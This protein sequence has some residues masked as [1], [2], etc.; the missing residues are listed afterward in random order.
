MIWA[1]VTCAG[2]SRQVPTTVL[3]VKVIFQESIPHLQKNKSKFPP[4]TAPPELQEEN[5]QDKCLY[6]VQ[7]LE[8]R[9]RVRVSQ[10]GLQR[11][12]LYKM[13]LKRSGYSRSV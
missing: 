3:Q 8:V 11:V 7:D 1:G 12:I 2:I 10:R 6:L 4:T 13:G 9:V 5:G